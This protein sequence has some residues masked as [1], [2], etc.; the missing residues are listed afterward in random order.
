MP[1]NDR[2]GQATIITEK[3]QNLI[4]KHLPSNIY[5]MMFWIAVYT[6]ERWG[7]ILQLKQADCY[8]YFGKPRQEITFRKHTRKA[9]TQG[10]Q[11]TR[12]IPVHE[13]L[14]TALAIWERPKGELMFPSPL[15]CS[16]PISF[17]SADRALRRAIEKAGLSHRGFSSHSTRRTFITRLIEAGVSLDVVQAMTGH[18]DINSLRR[19]VETSP[20]RIKKA[21]S[22][23][24]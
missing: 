21:L 14:S 23:L 3:E 5:R 6:G 19:Y 20:E 11:F 13:K 8:D 15:D 22:V 24:D 2:F 12:Q 16:Q 4:L 1:K 18:K 7:A 9:D 10:R 17:Q